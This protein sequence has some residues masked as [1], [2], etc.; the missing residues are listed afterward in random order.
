MPLNLLT[1]P[2]EEAERLAYSEGFTMAAQLFA[3]IADLEAERD[4][5]L[6]QLEELPSEKERNR[7]A[8]D[9]EQLKEFFYDC[10]QQL[11][12]HYPC[13]SWSNDHDKSVIFGAIEKGGPM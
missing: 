1:L 9:L 2:T 12:G 6:G 3:R 4:A 13:P 11:P 10:F 7:D 5:L 8:Q